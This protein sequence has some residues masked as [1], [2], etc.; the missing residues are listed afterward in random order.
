MAR[1]CAQ[2]HFSDWHVKNLL[3]K[4]SGDIA[5]VCKTFVKGAPILPISATTLE[6]LF[7]FGLQQTPYGMSRVLAWKVD[8]VARGK[9]VY[10]F[11]VG[12]NPERVRAFFGLSCCTRL[13]QSIVMQL[14]PQLRI[15]PL[16]AG[17]QRR[18][19][20]KWPT[21]SATGKHIAVAHLSKDQRLQ[22]LRQSSE[23]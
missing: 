12:V 11:G 15:Q 1:L 5:P 14:T 22:F 19:G 8:K 21:G 4:N 6:R 10:V 9:P 17:I 16:C 2:L 20:P 13:Q 23:T 7:V 3:P 18:H